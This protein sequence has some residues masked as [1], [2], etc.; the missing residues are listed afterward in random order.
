MANLA[1]YRNKTDERK[2]ANQIKSLKKSAAFR[3]DQGHKMPAVA[4]G[5]IQRAR[6]RP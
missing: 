4:M 3:R 1:M 5:V 6:S 2:I